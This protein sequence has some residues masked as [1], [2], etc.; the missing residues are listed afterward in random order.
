MSVWGAT[1]IFK[2]NV[3]FQILV[4]RFGLILYICIKN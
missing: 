1:P 2:I 4:L 3:D